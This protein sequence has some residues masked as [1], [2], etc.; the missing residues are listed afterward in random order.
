MSRRVSLTEAIIMLDTFASRLHNVRDMRMTH[1]VP[2]L[3]R[4]LARDSSRL[5]QTYRHLDRL[6]DAHERFL[7]YADDAQRQEERIRETI[8]ILGRENISQDEITDPVANEAFAGTRI[9]DLRKSLELWRAVYRVLYALDQPE[10]QVVD[11]RTMLKWFGIEAS[12]QAVEAAVKRHPETFEI[13]E[14]GRKRFIRVRRV[15]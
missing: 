7:R 12:R 4:E 14:Q 9:E 3:K 8:A 10:A 6:R 1:I 5:E 2:V 15:P 13:R 11:I